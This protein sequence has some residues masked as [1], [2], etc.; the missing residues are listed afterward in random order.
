MTGCISVASR[1]FDLRITSHTFKIRK[2][3]VEKLGKLLPSESPIVDNYRLWSF[4]KILFNKDFISIN[5]SD[6]SDY[7]NVKRK[8]NHNR[9]LTRKLGELTWD[10][11]KQQVVCLLVA[12]ITYGILM[13]VR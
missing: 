9:D 3:T 8:F 7:E 13:F 1:L 6:Y 12:I 5:E 11:H 10:T 4:T 2:K